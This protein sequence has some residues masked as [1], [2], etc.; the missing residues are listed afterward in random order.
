MCE[1]V[2]YY[3]HKLLNHRE[4]TCLVNTCGLRYLVY[5][6]CFSHFAYFTDLDCKF[7]NF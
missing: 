7:T 5:Y 1:A 4:N 3:N 6:I 2:F